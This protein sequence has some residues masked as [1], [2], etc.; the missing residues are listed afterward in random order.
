[1]GAAKDRAPE[2]TS[3]VAVDGTVKPRLWRTIASQPPYRQYYLYLA[4]VGETRLPQVASVY[5]VMFFLGSL[6]RCRP[7]YLLDILEGPYGPFVRE[8]LVTQPLQVVYAFACEFAKQEI[9]R[10]AVV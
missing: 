6:T 8:F 3:P 9:T 2:R 5:A 1:M 7:R 4:P 10:A